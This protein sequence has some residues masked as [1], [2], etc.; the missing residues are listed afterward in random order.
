VY[1]GFTRTRRSTALPILV[2]N[3]ARLARVVARIDV[4]LR[5]GIFLR[6]LA[7]IAGPS[8]LLLLLTIAA[9]ETPLLTIALLP[10][11]RLVA[12]AG[13]ASTLLLVRTI[14]VAALIVGTHIDASFSRR[15]AQ[16]D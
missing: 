2:A 7:P 1:S 6:D 11:T 10:A 16:P 15:N 9:R 8:T 3:L 5:D 14:G 4:I 12:A 13:F